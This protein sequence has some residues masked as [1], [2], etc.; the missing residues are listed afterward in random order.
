MQA[1]R[2]AVVEH[3]EIDP[4][5]IVLIRQTSLPITSSGKVQR[6]LC[7]QQYR[8][9]RAEGRSRVDQSGR[10]WR[11]CECQRHRP[12]G[13]MARAFRGLHR[14]SSSAPRR[15]ASSRR[16]RRPVGSVELDRATERIEAW[17]LDWLMTRLGL[18]PEDVSRDRPFAEYGV[19]SLTAV[20]MSHELEQQF[21]V[22]LPPIVAWNYPT[23]AA[24]A[25]FLAEETTGVKR[26]QP[27]EAHRTPRTDRTANP[28]A[29]QRRRKS[30]TDAELAAL[31]AEVE[32]LSDAEAAKLLGGR[33]AGPVGSVGVRRSGTICPH[34]AQR[35]SKVNTLC[36]LIFLGFLA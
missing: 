33:A 3:H 36:A 30:A 7:R 35:C 24:L 28:T 34:C 26:E 6:T 4:Y 23:P 9:G 14:M 32:N 1:I 11:G 22:P 20:E 29:R 16:R 13:S 12:C 5:A 21:S 15:M 27:A 17:M 8:G 2:R 25:R 10:E 19:D 31:L 18:S